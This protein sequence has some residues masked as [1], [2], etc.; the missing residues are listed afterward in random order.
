VGLGGWLM[1]EGYMLHT[2]GYGSPTS[3]RAQVEDVLGADDAALFWETYEANYV[4][5]KDVQAIAA[6]GF[7]HIRLPF[8]Y[9]VL[10]DADAGEFKEEGFQL[11]AEFMSWCRESGVGVILDMHAAPGGQNS[12]NISDSDGEARFWTEPGPNQTLAIEI[13]MEIARR[14]VDDPLVIGYDL[15]NEPVLPDGVP[16][17]A[18]RSFYE[19]AADSLRTIDTNHILFIEGNWFATDFSAIVP[20]FDDNMVYAF[21]K[22][23]NSTDIGSIRYLLDIRDRHNVPLWLG[24][25]GENSNTWARQTLRLMEEEG[26]GWNWWTHKKIDTATS[27]LSSEITPEYRRVLDY[28]SGSAPRPTQSF[29]RDALIGQAL[30]LDMDSC[31]VRP[32]LLA[33]LF[34]P[35]F[36]LRP[37]P[38]KPHVLPGAINAVDYD[39]GEQTVAYRDLDYKNQSGSPG[40]GN[41]GGK[42][43]NDGVDIERSTDP[44]GYEFNVGWINRSEWLL[45]TV[46][47]EQS[48]VYRLKARVASLSGEGGFDLEVDG[49]VAASVPSVPATG[50][51]QNWTTVE[52]KE[53]EL[54]AGLAHLRVFFMQ[55]GFNLNR[56]TFELVAPADVE[57]ACAD[58]PELV[59]GISLFPNP[60]RH[61]AKLTYSLDAPASVRFTIFDILGREVFSTTELEGSGGLREMQVDATSL[62][63][64]VY[65][66]T[67]D[68]EAAHRTAASTGSLVV[69]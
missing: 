41:T 1:P 68:A 32:D 3:I 31:D 7:D 27:P 64:G 5:R 28:W 58:L 44:E 10:Y 37:R 9:D 53:F 49:E 25:T 34:D 59:S 18:L 24:E 46:D 67:L 8:H 33:A 12:L 43:R 56:M 4:E 42:Y 65:F 54:T 45:Y 51:W 38:F 6:W 57:C 47:V 35:E 40:T 66:Y 17:S 23:W 22:Y 2:P 50:G 48:G 62:A 11:I 55:Q 14:Y 36:L 29:A 19:R 69:N 20:P 52:T 60:V 15:I 39:L 63:P 61:T 21:H 26:I 16:G 30:R 13:W